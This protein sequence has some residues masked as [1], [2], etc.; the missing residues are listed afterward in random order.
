MF[1]LGTRLLFDS[2]KQTTSVAVLRG[3]EA[4]ITS[5]SE[6]GGGRPD[7]DT[8]C[9]PGTRAKRPGTRG[10]HFSPSSLQRGNVLERIS[11]IFLLSF[12]YVTCH[13]PQAN[14][15][16]IICSFRE[17]TELLST[18]TLWSEAHLLQSCPLRTVT[19]GTAVFSTKEHGCPPWA[20]AVS[21]AT[22]QPGTSPNKARMTD[23]HPGQG[24]DKRIFR[25]KTGKLHPPP[26]IHPRLALTLPCSSCSP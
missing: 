1:T 13:K 24:E 22:A 9:A 20:L 16:L 3:P 4:L 19:D 7:R 14:T 18:E 8:I 11:R 12:T 10:L 6:T 17:S 21:S 23:N 15:P 5:V 2:W 26:P 25:V